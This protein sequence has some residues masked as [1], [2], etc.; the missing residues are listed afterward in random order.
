MAKKGDLVVYERSDRPIYVFGS[1]V[2]PVDEKSRKSYDVEMVTSATKE[3]KV[4]ATQSPPIRSVTR[5]RV[6]SRSVSASQASSTARCGSTSE[7]TALLPTRS[8]SSM[9]TPGTKGCL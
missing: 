4:K 8:G 7:P 2:K 3:G 6:S 9:C 1:K 5:R